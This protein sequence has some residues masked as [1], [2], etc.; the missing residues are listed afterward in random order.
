MAKV[1]EHQGS[2][3]DLDLLAWV[4][5][6]TA[7]LR[8]GQL[9]GLD[10]QCLIEELDATAGSLRREL[11]NRL[12]LLLAHLLEWQ[13]Q[14]KRRARSWAATIAEQRDQIADLLEE[15]PSL[16]REI[17]SAARAAYPQARK[18]AAIETGLP[19]ET[20]PADLPY[21]L[22]RITRDESDPDDQVRT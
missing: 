14:P 3:H 7:L 11:K 1:L 19:R 9:D 10:S 15:N 17:E 13:F 20:F 16:R 21:D 4:E 5:Q 18:R 12:R 6:Q 2:L 22:G 8:A